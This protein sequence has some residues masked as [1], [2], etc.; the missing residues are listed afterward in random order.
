TVVSM[1][2]AIAAGSACSRSSGE[3]STPAA[4][5]QSAAP[6]PI[7]P[8]SNGDKLR[9]TDL[10]HL[11]SIGDVHVSPDRSRIAY[12]VVN[13]NRPGRPYTQAWIM[14]VQ[15]RQSARLGSPAGTASN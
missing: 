8:P 14:N 2:A 4:A 13:N 7:P 6:V 3:A 5:A 9:P 15:S 12:S 11:H 10:Y 1:A